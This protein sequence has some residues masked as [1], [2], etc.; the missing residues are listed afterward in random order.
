MDLFLVNGVLITAQPHPE[1][2]PTGASG[3]I[4]FD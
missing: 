4:P 1:R 3:D 2:P